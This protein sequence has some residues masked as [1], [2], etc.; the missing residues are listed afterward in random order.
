MPSLWSYSNEKPST[1]KRNEETKNPPLPVNLA[2]L[3]AQFDALPPATI[4][5]VTFFVGGSSVLATGYMHR[6]YGKRIVNSQWVTPAHLQRKRWLKGVVT[7]VGD[8]DNFRLYHTPTIGFIWPLKWKTVPTTTK[9]LKNETIHIRIAGVDAPEAS[10]FGKPG[11]PFAAEALTWL[12][13]QILGK[14]VYCQ[15]LKQD[16][17]GRIVAEVQCSPRFLPGWFFNGKS[18][19]EEM[20]RAGWGVTYEQ[21]G[22]LYGKIGKEG[23]MQLEKQA[24]KAKNGMWKNGTGIESPAEYKRRV[25][26]ESSTVDKVTPASASGIRPQKSRTRRKSWW[27]RAFSR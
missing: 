20:L 9:D 8:A 15:L 11:Q 17:Y 23:Y 6:R 2:K 5:L 4:A 10:H 24:K 19:A 12:R 14:V 16:Q 18:V 21:A 26:S 3:K 7:S 25:A 22:A 27:K 1:E 13:S